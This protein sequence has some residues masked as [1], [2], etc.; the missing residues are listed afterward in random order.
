MRYVGEQE[1]YKQRLAD[2]QGELTSN[3]QLIEKYEQRHDRLVLEDI[4]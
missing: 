3:A 1:K 4:E 2:A